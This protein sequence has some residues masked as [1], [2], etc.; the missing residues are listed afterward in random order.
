MTS[1]FMSQGPPLGTVGVGGH[2][3]LHRHHD[4]FGVRFGFD[5]GDGG[6]QALLFPDVLGGFQPTHHGRFNGR[7]INLVLA[8]ASSKEEIR[9]VMVVGL[10][11]PLLTAD[12]IEKKLILWISPVLTRVKTGHI[13]VELRDHVVAILMDIFWG[14][15]VKVG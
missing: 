8:K 3:E 10:W 14:Q 15:G 7:N 5:D 4:I 13:A 2:Q 11:A 6:A 9:N 12:F 1:G